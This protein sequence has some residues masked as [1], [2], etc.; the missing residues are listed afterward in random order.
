MT[1]I[2]PLQ[3]L[4]AFN[5]APG[6]DPGLIT[7]VASPGVLGAHNVWTDISP[8]VTGAQIGRGTQHEMGVFEAGTCTLTLDNRAGT[9]NPWNTASPFYGLLLPMKLVQVRAT[10][11]GTTFYRFTGH[12]S[13]WPILWPDP[14]SSGAELVASDAFRLFNTSTL[15]TVGLTLQASGARIGALLDLIGWPAGARVIDTGSTNIQADVQN[16][17]E[18]AALGV[19]QSVEE[20]EAGALFMDGQG[21]VRFIQRGALSYSTGAP[22]SPYGVVQAVLGDEPR[23]GE[24]PFQPGPTLGLDELD[25]YNRAV[26]TRQGGT[27]QVYDDTGSQAA[28]G[29][30]VWKPSSTV[31]YT[32]DAEALNRALYVV[33]THAQPITRLAAISVDLNDLVEPGTVATMLGLDLLYRV[34]VNRHGPPGGGD[35][36][37]QDGNVEH[38][39]EVISANGW[40]ITLALAPADT[41]GYWTWGTS[42]WA[43]LPDTTRWD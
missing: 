42:E 26:V 7:T 10:T 27:E 30:H 3:C 1:A 28:Y 23:V 4:V 5:N 24:I 20:T 15:S 40:T 32:S 34:T 17:T 29:V 19:L 22:T 38:I 6:D 25:I 9:F 37:H 16:L 36:F 33:T 35:A 8:W 41:S 2:P 31:L 21:R 14:L 43:T 13:A 18:A 12:T 39:S 11:G